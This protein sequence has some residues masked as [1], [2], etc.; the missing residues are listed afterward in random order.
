MCAM[1]T[2][3][4]HPEPA[5]GASPLEAVQG[6]EARE[7]FGPEALLAQ[8]RLA[9]ASQG[10]Q[11]EGWATLDGALGPRWAAALAAECRALELGGL[12]QPHC[13]EFAA[14]GAVGAA[15]GRSAYQHP[16]RSYVDLDACRVR[17]EVAA[18]APLLA[19]FALARAPELAASLSKALPALELGAGADAVQVK[20]Q[21]T[22]GE[23]GC[24][25][26][27][28]DTSESAATRQV[29]LLVYLSEDWR[30]ECGGELQLLPFLQAPVDLLPRHDRGV[31]FLS[32]RLLHR[33]LP[34]QGAAGVTMAR[35]LL[36]VWFDG[37]AVDAKRGSVFPP[38]LQRMVT[39]AVYRELY[40][41]ALE[42]SLPPGS[43][44][45]ALCKAQADEIAAI[46]GDEELA[47]MLDDLREAAADLAPPRPPKRL[48]GGG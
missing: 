19:S 9:K 7:A 40:L 3:G 12:L 30:D 32:D 22:R 21:L 1:E 39:P 38:L 15:G 44:R 18:A 46:E 47:E 24:A 27:H 45:A 31:L 11:Q 41:E 16:G 42:Q 23:H 35:W 5:P 34:P 4:L 33:S 17:P 43:A 25:P 29:T 28:Y 6:G 37:S 2:P 26:W 14:P 48:R 13:F 10:L 36:T 20:L 8:R